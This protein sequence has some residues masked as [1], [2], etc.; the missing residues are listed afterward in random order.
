MGIATED[1]HPLKA[2]REARGLNRE[3]LA[4]RAGVSMKTVE[5]I[6]RGQ[7]NPQRSTRTVLALA[8]GCAA[9]DIWPELEAA[10]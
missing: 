9:V 2:A 4:S 6:E 8:L 1:I 3:T 10:A 7:V 5:L